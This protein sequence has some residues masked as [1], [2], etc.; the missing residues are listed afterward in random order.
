MLVH[1]H[2]KWQCCNIIILYN[3]GQVCSNWI[4]AVYI[5]THTHATAIFQWMLYISRLE[6]F[7]INSGIDVSPVIEKLNSSSKE[8]ETDNTEI[9][10]PHN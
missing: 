6:V 9:N 5:Y 4:I 2:I 10:L 3:A 8:Q 7:N 1:A